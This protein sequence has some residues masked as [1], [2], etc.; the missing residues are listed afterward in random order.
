MRKLMRLLKLHSSA[1][2]IFALCVF[3]VQDIKALQKTKNPETIKI[4]LL[5]ADN[6][7]LAA[8]HGAEMAILK[9]NET[10]GYNKQP[11]QLIVRSM[12]GPWGTGSK[13]AVN[14]IFD[15][16]VLAI[17]GSHDGRNAHLVEQVT[18]KAQIV[19]LS[20]WA[21]DPTLSQAFVPWFFSCVPN[22]NQQAD[23]LIEEIYN[24]RKF[25]KIAAV[26]DNDYDSKLALISFLNKIKLAGKADPFQFFYN[27]TDADLN[28]IPD[29]IKKADVSCII[30][31]GG[32]SASIKIIQQLRQRKMSQPVFGKL[33]LLDDKE[34]SEN[35]LRNYED[36]VL[37][38]PDQLSG[39][40]VLTFRDDFQKV[41][42]YKPGAIAAY[43][44]DG[45]NL[46]IDAIRIAGPDSEKIRKSLANIN[47]EGITGSIHFDSKGNREGPAILV[48]MKHG[49]PVAVEK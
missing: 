38:A 48:K 23:V 46:L 29:Q 1:Y 31:F 49:I 44:F 34:L 36:L 5:I 16:E 17:M 12:E 14:L 40:K 4:G 30:L 13:E 10:G 9:A 42:G 24:K 18:T 33:S 11:F 8:K 20:A 32:P 47:Y 45:M 2:V 15:E 37:I 35:D 19:F 3:L 6:K 21:S 25:S 7:S 27:N 26:S 39:S 43:A 28:N 22:D 41:Y